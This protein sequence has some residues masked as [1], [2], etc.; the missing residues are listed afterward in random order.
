MGRIEKIR[1]GDL[2]V[3]QKVISTE[4]LK[5]ALEL[6][7]RSGRRLGKILVENGFVTDEQVYE[8]LSRQLNIP[9]IN[10]KFF[11]LAPD[12]SRKLPETMARR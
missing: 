9:Y 5:S 1:L 2:L 3:A 8:A 12:V 4:Q 7:K 6:Q 11:N 10:L